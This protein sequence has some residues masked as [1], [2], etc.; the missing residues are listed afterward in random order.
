MRPIA[1]SI[2]NNAALTKSSQINPNSVKSHDVRDSSIDR[3]GKTT[4]SFLAEH[5]PANFIVS[6]VHKPVASFAT[7]L[8]A[9]FSQDY[10]AI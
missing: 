4:K 3:S 8:V 9:R 7:K 10:Q 5:L 6:F 2:C 1:F